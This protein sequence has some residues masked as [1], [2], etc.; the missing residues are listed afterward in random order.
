MWVILAQ[1]LTAI[2]ALASIKVATTVLGPE[3]YGR[4]AA[5]VAVAAIIQICLFGSISQAAARFL[6]LAINAGNWTSYVRSLVRLVSG[7]SAIIVLLCGLSYLLP[8]DIGSTTP[9][10]LLMLFPIVAGC[11]QVLTTALNAGR[12]RKAVALAQGV[13]TIV[14]PMMMLGA[15]FAFG[16]E[17]S[18]VLAAYIASSLLVLAV[19]WAV[20]VRFRKEILEGKPATPSVVGADLFGQMIAY[21][22]PFVVFGVVG[23][24]GSHGERFLLAAWLPWEQVGVYALLSQ[25]ALAPTVLLMNLVNQF[26]LPVVFQHDPHG[27]K[28]LAGTARGYFIVSAVGTAVLATAIVVAGPD[29]VRLASTRAFLGYEYLLVP[30]VI[31]AALFGMAQQLWLPGLRALRTVIY[32]V[33][34][35]VHTVSL[36]T[37]AVLLVPAF[38]LTGMAIASLIAASLYALSVIVANRLVENA[39]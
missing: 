11:Q 4:F 3:N 22:L 13:E 12:L 18:A 29:L 30:L 9:V 39:A 28:V 35:T 38:G 31:S 21:V 14:R 32:I 15:S 26:Y 19:L 27:K 2:G 36:L 23:A 34:K 37:A 8:F 10:W 20:F 16:A 25:L 5:A 17:I 33:P 7:A 1:G 24:V 6:F